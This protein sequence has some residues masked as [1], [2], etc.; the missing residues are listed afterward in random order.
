[1]RDVSIYQQ[2]EAGQKLTT[3]DSDA[4]SLFLVDHSYIY[5]FKYIDDTL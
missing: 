5:L 3:L 2:V 4:Y 1:M